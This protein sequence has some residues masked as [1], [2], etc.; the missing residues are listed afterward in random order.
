[1]KTKKYKFIFTDNST[2]PPTYSFGNKYNEANR[3]CIKTGIE[4]FFGACNTSALSETALSIM[5][6]EK[7]K[8]SLSHEYGLLEHNISIHK[9]VSEL[10]Y[11]DGVDIYLPSIDANRVYINIF[12]QLVKIWE[13]KV[14][15]L[16]EKPEY[17]FEIVQQ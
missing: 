6:L 16:K 5:M 15:V 4:E 2:E 14:R 17:I 7:M 1:M 11:A 13:E 3:H 10:G 12:N 8:E 9:I